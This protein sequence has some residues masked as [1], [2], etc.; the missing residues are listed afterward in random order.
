MVAFLLWEW[1][2]SLFT[3]LSWGKSH[4][5]VGTQTS[6]GLTLNS[7]HCF[8]WH[9][10]DLWPSPALSCWSEDAMDGSIVRDFEPVPEGPVL[11]CSITAD[12]RRWLALI[13][14]WSGRWEGRACPHT[15]CQGPFTVFSANT[16]PSTPI[17]WSHGFHLLLWEPSR[18]GDSENFKCQK[19]EMYCDWSQSECSS[20]SFFPAVTPVDQLQ[21]SLAIQCRPSCHGGNRGPGRKPE[22][23][24]GESRF[25]RPPSGAFA[26]TL[27]TDVRWAFKR[28]FAL[29]WICFYPEQQLQN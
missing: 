28:G 27:H 19:D 22:L 8:R 2:G 25:G 9:F 18:C 23:S 5:T 13:W 26:F 6:L 20:W 16:R 24:P 4:R 11:E 7:A 3:L 29:K 1:W 21:G 12:S 10:S 14:L 15:A 17:C